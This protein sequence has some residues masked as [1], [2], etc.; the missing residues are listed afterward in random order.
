MVLLRHYALRL[1]KRVSVSTL[2]CLGKVVCFPSGIPSSFY[3]WLQCKAN[4]WNILFPH[5]GGKMGIAS[6]EPGRVLS[7]LLRWWNGFS[8][9]VL[10][11]CNIIKPGNMQINNWNWGKKIPYWFD[12]KHVWTQLCVSSI[13]ISLIG[14]TLTQ[15]Y[16]VKANIQQPVPVQHYDTFTSVVCLWGIFTLGTIC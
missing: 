15:P 5:C 2:A 12:N 4:W 13:S 11:K 7:L 9:A 16:F 3:E 1:L 10:T 14:R 6:Q 8:P